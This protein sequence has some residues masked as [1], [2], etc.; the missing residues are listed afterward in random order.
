MALFSLPGEMKAQ[1]KHAVFS[2]D[3]DGDGI[4]DTGGQ[5]KCPSTLIKIQG[6]Q[7]TALDEVSGEEVT[8]RLPDNLSEYVYQ[9]RIPLDNQIKDLRKEQSNYRQTLKRVEIRYGKYK[10]LKGK[11]QKAKIAELQA[12]IAEYDVQIDSVKQVIKTV[13]PNS[14]IEFVGNVTDKDGKVLKEKARVRIRIEVDMFGCLTDDDQDGSPNMVDL[15]PDQIGTV[16]SSG[17]PDRD[18]DGIPDRTDECPTIKGPR[19]SGCPDRDGDGLADNVDKCPNDPGPKELEGCPDRDR[20]GILD[21]QDDCPDDPGPKELKGCPD[22][23]KDTVL[24]R[25]DECPDVPG[26]VENKGCPKILEKASRVLFEVDKAII[27]PVSY[28]ILDELVAL[29]KEYPNSYISLAGHTDSDGSDAHNLE[30][31]KN[32][33]RAVRTYLIE[34]GIAAQR[35]TATGYGESQPIADNA[36]EAGRQKNR[37]VEM[38]LSNQ[39]QD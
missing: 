39:P 12:T 20:D 22:R 11:E 8:I 34:H 23:D 13:D 9:D 35:I 18:R 36:T 17:C 32:R 29:L 31:S 2:A 30:L 14:Y 24:D 5:D 7:A 16:E 19:P 15:C 3:L 6:R 1:N 21:S 25:D 10:D 28:S 27:K 37:R 26:V 38:K 4:A 33:A